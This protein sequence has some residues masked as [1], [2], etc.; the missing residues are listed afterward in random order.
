M[1]LNGSTANKVGHKN[2][3]SPRL[4]VLRRAQLVMDDKQ[5]PVRMRNISETGV[6]LE[7]AEYLSP[8]KIG[9]LLVQDG[10]M[11]DV[12]CVW[13]S[14]HRCGLAFDAT[15]DLGW[16]AVAQQRAAQAASA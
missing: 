13:W 7:V 2:S 14:D 3:R 6:M 8:G 4:S 9:Q 12:R 1:G 5:L 15:V 10:P 11:L 16:L